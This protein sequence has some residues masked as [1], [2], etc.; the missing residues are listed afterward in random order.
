MGI[1]RFEPLQIALA[2]LSSYVPG[3]KELPYP[4]VFTAGKL[5][6]VF[7]SRAK[8]VVFVV[9]LVICSS[10]GAQATAIVASVRT[11][12]LQVESAK[13]NRLTSDGMGSADLNTEP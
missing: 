3:F 10:F 11:G 8:V 6:D 4:D 1:I 12:L 2:I 9:A 13:F 5:C 7:E